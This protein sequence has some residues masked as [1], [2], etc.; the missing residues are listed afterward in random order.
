[1][2]LSRL[3]LVIGLM[4][5]SPIYGQKIYVVPPTPTLAPG[6]TGTVYGHVLCGD[7]GRPARMASVTLQPVVA[8]PLPTS[9]TNSSAS[10]VNRSAPT[11]VVQTLMDGSF[12][13]PNV[14]PGD[15]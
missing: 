14:S 13:I 4:A 5:W 12:T 15:Y 9:P 2:S 7:S 3:A 6:T 11:T 8:S 10:R 1:M